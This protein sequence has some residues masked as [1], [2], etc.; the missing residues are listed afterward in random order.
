M[1][2]LDLATIETSGF[3]L[4]EASAGT[5]KTWTITALYCLLLLEQR[6]RPEEI[7]VVTYTKSATAELRDRIRARI[8]DTLELYT[9]GRPPRDGLEEILL[10]TRCTDKETAI[11]LLTRGLYS[12]DDAAIFTIHGFC[13]RALRENAFESGSLFDTDMISDQATILRD[14]CDDFWRRQI[15]TES[16][17]FLKRLSAEGYTPGKLA[18]PFKGHYQN[19]SLAVIPS[20]DNPD[21]TPLVACCGRIAPDLTRLWRGERDA[22]L[23]QLLQAN[24]SQ[25]SYKPSQ[26][27]TA[28]AG[29]DRWLATDDAA[30]PCPGLR[31]FTNDAIKTGQKK[32]STLPTHPFFGLCQQ[33]HK[34][35]QQV[36]HAFNHRL[37]G[38]QH[39]RN[40]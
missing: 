22:I 17:E 13:Q 36:E 26:I 4:I 28:A 5:G 21:L 23:Q 15:M 35:L 27:E 2:H 37:I 14:I 3:H 18:E 1:K 12:F 38:H 6:M 40:P 20:T 25:T 16:D 30:A 34:A 24:L 39:C 7:L 19:P 8:S 29:L 33:M 11:K 31:L 9:S 10:G 32:G